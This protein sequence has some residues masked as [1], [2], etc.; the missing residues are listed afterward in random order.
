MDAKDRFLTQLYERADG[1][2]DRTVHS[3]LHVA[4]PLAYSIIQMQANAD[5][6]IAEGMI[7]ADPGYN[8]LIRLTP[9]GVAVYQRTHVGDAVGSFDGCGRAPTAAR[10]GLTTQ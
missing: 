5:A 2:I 8:R 7:E 6:L 1:R 3:Y 4:K 10:V 9:F